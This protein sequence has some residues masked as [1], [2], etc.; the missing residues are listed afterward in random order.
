MISTLISF[1]SYQ[2]IV[3]LIGNVAVW[4]DEYKQSLIA[5]IPLNLTPEQGAYLYRNLQLSINDYEAAQTQMDD[6][7]LSAVYATVQ[8]LETET[9]DILKKSEA[10]ISVSERNESEQLFQSL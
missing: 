7:Y 4:E 10:D 2:K 5:S 3:E 6:E 9:K 1:M 8:S